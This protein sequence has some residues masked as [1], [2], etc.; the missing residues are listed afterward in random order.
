[1][2]G[3]FLPGPGRPHDGTSSYNCGR[4]AADCSYVRRPG[5]VLTVPTQS[6]YADSVST[7]A[8]SQSHAFTNA[9]DQTSAGRLVVPAVLSGPD[10]AGCLLSN[11]GPAAHTNPGHSAVHS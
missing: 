7:P 8:S 11:P 10:D 1:M 2:A 6:H 5:F 3:P 9:D 4:T